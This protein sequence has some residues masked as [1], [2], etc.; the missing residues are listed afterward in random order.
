[1]Y[2]AT[3]LTAYFECQRLIQHTNCE[4][5]LRI[6]ARS[7]SRIVAA[8][9]RHSSLP[10]WGHILEPRLT[11]RHVASAAAPEFKHAL[12]QGASRGLGLEIVTQLLQRPD[13][14]CASTWQSPGPAALTLMVLAMFCHHGS[15]IASLVPTTLSNI[16]LA[17]SRKLWNGD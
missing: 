12:I 5:M 1:M 15:F 8:R 6:C 7:A 4:A 10:S 9:S 11:D 13:H 17:H 2:L 16:T 14:K 3:V